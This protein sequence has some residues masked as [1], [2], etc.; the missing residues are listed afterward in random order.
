MSVNN[1]LEDGE[2]R[3]FDEAENEQPLFPNNNSVNSSFNKA[4]SRWITVEPVIFLAFIG[5]GTFSTIRSE[6]LQ[7]RIAK[8]VYN[9]TYPT[10]S[11]CVIANTSD[12]DYITEQD[13][14]AD[15]ANWSLYLSICGFLPLIFTA[16]LI[17]KWSDYAG[18]KKALVLPLIGMLIQST[19]YLIVIAV[20]LPMPVLFAGEFAYGLTGGSPLLVSIS[21]AYIADITTMVQRTFRV[22][23]VETSIVIPIGFAQLA[24]GYLIQASGFVP[25]FYLLLASQL[26][27]IAYMGI[28]G[29]L[30]ESI[31]SKHEGGRLSSRMVKLFHGIT[32]LFAY[33]VDNR[34]WRL[35]LINAIF[36]PII[37]VIYGYTSIITLYAIGQPFCWSSVLV[38][39]YMAISLVLFSFS[40]YTLR[41]L[42]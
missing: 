2:T 6:Y 33:N 9:Y 32:D 15:A 5:N 28:P 24:I 21:L 30:Y 3:P 10:N 1:K 35:L 16:I 23:V 27:A 42:C 13:I 39:I 7:S 12:P 41:L 20:H 22:V 29:L 11:S 19:V 18:R 38:G 36:F 8:D 26:T 25:P 37:F 40:K 17:G 34:R 4:K 14:Q 31:Q